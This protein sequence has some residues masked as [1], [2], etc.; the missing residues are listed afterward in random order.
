[1]ARPQSLALVDVRNRNALECVPEPVDD[2]GRL[3][4]GDHGQL[5]GPGVNRRLESV[6]KQRPPRNV[7]E[8]LRS[9]SRQPTD[10]TASPGGRDNCVHTGTGI[11]HSNRRVPVPPREAFHGSDNSGSIS[12]LNDSDSNRLLSAVP[13][14]LRSRSN[15]GKCASDCAGTRVLSPIA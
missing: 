15:T 4:P 6:R 10:P 7:D 5:V 2:L 8:S 12:G 3:V 11:R 13:N 14:A 1:M 9:V